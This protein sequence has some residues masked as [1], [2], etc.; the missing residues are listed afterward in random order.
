MNRY[1]FI[2][3]ATILPSTL[4]CG[5]SETDSSKYFGAYGEVLQTFVDPRDNKE[6]PMVVLG[7][8]TW[9]ASNLSYQMLGAEQGPLDQWYYTWEAALEAC[10]EGWYLPGQKEFKDLVETGGGWEVA[11]FALKGR[12]GWEPGG[13]GLNMLGF[14][15]HP[16]GLITNDG[17]SETL[18]S[19]AHFWSSKRSHSGKSFYWTLYSD[20]GRLT[21][22]YGNRDN[23]L[24]I[25][26]VK[27]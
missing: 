12:E 15:A 6:Y 9:M 24:T 23:K 27:E 11:G 25:R 13:R 2:I 20:S 10:P 26:C 22:I 17:S 18:G 7:K 3:L 19:N 14:D 1:F 21:T 4:A 5:Q 8:H 16:F